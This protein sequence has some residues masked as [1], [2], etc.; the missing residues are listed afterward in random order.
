MDSNCAR[1]HLANTHALANSL[2]ALIRPL[3]HDL[4]DEPM[5]NAGHSTP[6]ILVMPERVGDPVA[7]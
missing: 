2:S 3:R 1:K 7:T 4:P 5:R 6:S